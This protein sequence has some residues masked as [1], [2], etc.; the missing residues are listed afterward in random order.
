MYAR[1]KQ[2]LQGMG[3]SIGGNEAGKLNSQ[4]EFKADLRD[5]RVNPLQ[6]KSNDC[7][8]NARFVVVINK[9]NERE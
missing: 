2:E 4:G 9:N 8:F 6:S 1:G 5:S 3:L 7:S